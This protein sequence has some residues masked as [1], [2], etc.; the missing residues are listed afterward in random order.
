M[1]V[2]IYA[3]TYAVLN[4]SIITEL[5]LFESTLSSNESNNESTVIPLA[6]IHAAVTVAIL[7]ANA[8]IPVEGIGGIGIVKLVSP[9]LPSVPL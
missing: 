4:L 7:A 3:C 1:C 9:G 8:I 6:A 5:V 2:C